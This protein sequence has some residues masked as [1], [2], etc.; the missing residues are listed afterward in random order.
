MIYM[1]LFAPRPSQTP[2]TEVA[3]APDAGASIAPVPAPAQATPL[4]QPEDVPLREVRREL[5]KVHYTFSSRGG[6]LTKAE[7][8]GEK[9][10][11]QVHLSYWEGLSLL[12]GHR[13]PSAPQMDMGAPVPGLPLPLA[14][15][16]QGAQALSESANYRI[17]ETADQIRF[18][19]VSGGWEVVKMLQWT[20]DGEELAFTVSV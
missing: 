20:S 3:G 11:E 17:E 10:R 16:I 4:L 14:V 13:P 8:Q 2:K 5:S 6:G 7:L 19:A 9:M 1:M 12:W 18:V 15:S